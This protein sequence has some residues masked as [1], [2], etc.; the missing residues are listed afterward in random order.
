MSK[1]I[2]I[3]II[4]DEELAAKKLKKLI[5]ESS[6]EI[7]E[8]HHAYSVDNAV[9][10]LEVNEHPDLFFMDIRL[11]DGLSFDILQSVEITRPIVFTTAYDEYAIK[12]FKVNSIDYLLKPVNAEDL[13]IALKKYHTLYSESTVLPPSLMD[14]IK[15]LKLSLLPN[16]YRERYLVKSGTQTSV[17]NT[18][19]IAYYYTED[20]CSFAKTY[21]G[22]KH[23]LDL[24]L[25]QIQKEEDPKKL[26]RINRSM[27]IKDE[28]IKK[29]EPYFN[30]R[31]SLTIEPE[32]SEQVIVAR[33]KVREFREWFER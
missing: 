8:I 9:S 26:F 15:Q 20:G 23:I 3:L 25:D 1:A 16:N 30:S 21:T 29:M 18:S 31:I 17:L 12:A 5:K 14:D 32:Y 19:E 28:C 7:G 11:G 22:K 4:E 6:F 24:T 27:L 10:F 33:E 2:S 13:N